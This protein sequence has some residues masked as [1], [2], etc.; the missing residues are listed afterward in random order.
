MGGGPHR[1]EECA[2]GGRVPVGGRAT[3]LVWL[4]MGALLMAGALTVILLVGMFTMRQDLGRSKAKV[5]FTQPFSKSREINYL[6]FARFFLF[7]RA[8]SG[9]WWAYRYFAEALNWSFA[10]VGAFMAAWVIGYGLIQA[11]ALAFLRNGGAGA[12]LR[13][14]GILTAVT[15]SLALWLSLNSSWD[16]RCCG[17]G[18][19]RNG[20]CGELSSALLSDPGLHQF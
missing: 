6:S 12:A 10:A 5:K 13:W 20:L 4:P 11:G 19:L 8:I 2:Q 16:W 1:F 9:S 15:G 14:A 3:W 7:D 18:R 17:S